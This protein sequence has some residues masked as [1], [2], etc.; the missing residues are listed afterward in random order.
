MTGERLNL[1]DR[2]RPKFLE[3]QFDLRC[4]FQRLKFR[5]FLSETSARNWRDPAVII[6]RGRS[7]VG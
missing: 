3:A 1:I 7:S 2:R 6:V 5:D 4:L